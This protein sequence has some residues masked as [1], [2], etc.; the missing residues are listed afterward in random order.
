MTAWERYKHARNET[1][2]VIKS[3]ERQYFIY[4]LEMNET[5]PRKASKDA[6]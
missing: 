3:A 2:N 5:N 1:N 6:D 4:N